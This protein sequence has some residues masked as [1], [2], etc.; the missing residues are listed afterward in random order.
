MLRVVDG[1]ERP[2][3]PKFQALMSHAKE[4]INKAFD[5]QSNKSLLKRIMDIVERQW[6][7]QTDHP[8]YGAVLYLNSGKLHSLI[9]ED[10]DS[11]V[12]QLMGLVP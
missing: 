6:L 2:A 8:L 5:I 12:G 3:M 1:D 11:A 9:K 10:D 4:T 7:K